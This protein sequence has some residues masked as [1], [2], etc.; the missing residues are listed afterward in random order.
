M[1]F[2]SHNFIFPCASALERTQFVLFGDKLIKM[3][4]D[5]NDLNRNFLISLCLCRMLKLIH[6]LNPKII[7]FR[8]RIITFCLL[9]LIEAELLRLV[10]RFL[11]D[12]CKFGW[13]CLLRCK[14]F[15][16]GLIMWRLWIFGL[17]DFELR[18]FFFLLY[19]YFTFSLEFSF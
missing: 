7:R 18:L 3:W 17:L 12:R 14:E 13:N 19:I 8:R 2:K 4:L 15:P 9:M 5:L 11:H 6:C 1:L 10:C 16:M